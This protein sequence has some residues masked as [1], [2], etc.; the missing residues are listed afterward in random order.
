MFL[1]YQGGPRTD[2]RAQTLKGKT[3]TE[4]IKGTPINITNINDNLITVRENKVIK[5]IQI[6]FI[7]NSVN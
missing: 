3:T 4:E 7:F 6:L 1:I 5:P 2:S